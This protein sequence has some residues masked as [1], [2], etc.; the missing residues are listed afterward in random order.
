MHLNKDA[1]VLVNKDDKNG[2]KMLEGT[3]ANKFSYALRSPADYKC[4]VLENQFDGMLLQINKVDVW[5][6]LI[7][8]FNA[9]NILA[10]YAVAKQFG[11][12]CQI[13]KCLLL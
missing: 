2:N 10:V 6:K 9:Y 7:G 4:K 13:M 5:V 12:D 11:L 3:K 8:D 1:F